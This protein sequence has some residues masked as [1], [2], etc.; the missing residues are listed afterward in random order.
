MS[1]NPNTIR[2]Q[3][4]LPSDNLI[5][6][7]K[8]L[9]G[10][11]NVIEVALVDS[12]VV[13]LG[14][15]QILMYLLRFHRGG[16]TGP[17][18]VPPQVIAGTTE[19]DITFAQWTAGT[20]AQLTFTIEPTDSSVSPLIQ[21]GEELSLEM[22]FITNAAPIIEGFI[23]NGSILFEPTS[24]AGSVAP[25]PQRFYLTRDEVFGLFNTIASPPYPTILDQVNLASPSYLTGLGTGASPLAVDV[26][27][28]AAV[29]NSVPTG[30]IFDFAAA[31]APAGFLLCDGSEAVRAT[32]PDLYAA[33]GDTY[34]AGDGSTT[35]NLPDL[36]GRVVAGLDDMGGTAANRLETGAN[37]ANFDATALGNNGGSQNHVLTEGQ[38][39]AHTHQSKENPG[40]AAGGIHFGRTGLGVN[41]SAVESAGGDEPHPN[42]QPTMVLNKIIKT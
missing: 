17:M 39:A 3:A 7:G 41:P 42:V 38:L 27:A 29:I 18:I 4:D 21:S 16:A 32:Y 12:G 34:G 2:I 31:A 40:Y 5:V 9:Q 20:H 22:H 33:I 11:T 36:R 13:Q 23:G 37:N 14:G 15:N 19:Q 30:A 8:L 28:L 1:L 35:F 25:E 26:T 24:I 6:T 10:V